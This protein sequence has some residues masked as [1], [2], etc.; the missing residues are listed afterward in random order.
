MKFPLTIL[1]PSDGV[2]HTDAERST[3]LQEL[4]LRTKVMAGQ[5]SGQ[6]VSWGCLIGLDHCLEHQEH[7]HHAC[8]TTTDGVAAIL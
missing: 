1:E 3:A 2:S 8:R 7:G 4:D 6:T 5:M